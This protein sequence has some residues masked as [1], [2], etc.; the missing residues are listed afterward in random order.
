MSS[1][2][3]DKIVIACARYFKNGYS[4]KKCQV[5]LN[6]QTYSWRSKPDIVAFA[7]EKVVHIIEVEPNFKKAFNTYVLHGIEQ[8]MLC[9]GD[10]RW[11][12]LPKKEY[13]KNPNVAKEECSKKHIGL[14]TSE[15]K[16]RGVQIQKVLNSKKSIGRLG[17]EG[18]GRPPSTLLKL[19]PNVYK[20]F[21]IGEDD[22]LKLK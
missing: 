17:S 2:L 1:D 8:I 21:K 4:S 18:P 19:Y 6:P 22:S 5:Y 11:I 16:G 9:P 12:A 7:N 13:L 10:R 3:H 14:L 15:T 20:R